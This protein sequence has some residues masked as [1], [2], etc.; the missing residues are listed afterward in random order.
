M[1]ANVLVFRKRLLAYSETFIADQGQFLPSMNPIF[2]GFRRDSSGL[3]LLQAMPRCLQQ[4]HSSVS[5][6]AR[7]RLRLG[8]GL[9][10]QW[11]DSLRNH[12]PKVLH[13]HFGPDALA[14]IPICK[15]LN[16]PLVATFHGFDITKNDTGAAW[17]RSRPAVFKAAYAVIAVSDYIRRA[18]LDSG[19][20]EEKIRQHYIGINT[21]LFQGRKQEAERPTV[22]FIGR[23]VPKKG[24]AYLI[25]AMKRVQRQL[26][27]A[28]LK[29]VG[30]GPLRKELGERAA[31]LRNVEFLGVKT[32]TEIRELLQEAWTLC[33]PSIV[34]P[35]GDAEGLGMVFLEAQALATPAVSFDTGGVVEAIEHG[36]TGLNV[37]S[38]DVGALADGL[39]T[40]LTDK[41][42]R[43]AW[44]AAGRRR[45]H[46][47]FN[48]RT[49]CG[50]LEN[51][52]AEAMEGSGA[53]L[54]DLY[55]VQPAKVA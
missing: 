18:L 47:Q 23:L 24:C 2:T 55:D 19:C 28:R 29:I 13:A 51:I 22:L 35:S 50:A 45:V 17:K 43:Q 34:A 54:R 41:P 31:S 9:N 49:Q 40:L 32:K 20:P 3:R 30:D 48:V 10:R 14:A 25:D 15:E 21:E 39:L 36:K 37:P 8:G 53:S 27:D 38:E 33:V 6:L 46:S 42:L 1:S 4:D 26:P 5:R 16:I 12:A 11:R 52:Y 7:L 44:G